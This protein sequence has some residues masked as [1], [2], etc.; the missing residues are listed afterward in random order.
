MKTPRSSPF[1]H[2]FG[3]GIKRK[4]TTKGSCIYLPTDPQKNGLQISPR[5]SP[6]KG[7]ENHQKGKP[8]RTQTSL[9][10]PRRIIYT[11]HEGSYKV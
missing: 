3:R 5:K 7:S 2:G 11:N 8:G 1:S 10:E 4:R 9:E 6:R